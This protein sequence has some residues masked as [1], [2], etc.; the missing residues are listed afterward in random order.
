MRDE[1]PL[2]LR[3]GILTYFRNPQQVP[4]DPAVADRIKAKIK[5]IRCCS[6]IETGQLL[7]LTSY[8]RVSKGDSDIRIVYDLTSYGLNDALWDT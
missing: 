2:F 6:Y 4:K 8:L 1:M 7:R 3:R 5:N